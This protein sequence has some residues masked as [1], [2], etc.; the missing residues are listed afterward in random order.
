MVLGGG[1]QSIERRVGQ[2]RAIHIIAQEN[3]MDTW[4]DE[5]SSFLSDSTD[6]L[7]MG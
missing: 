7:S 5:I 2:I 3:S 6:S 4:A 1:C